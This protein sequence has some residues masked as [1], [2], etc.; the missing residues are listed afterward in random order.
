MHIRLKNKALTNYSH[1]TNYCI[2]QFIDKGNIDRWH[3]DNIHI[4]AMELVN[5]IGKILTDL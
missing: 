2:A 4:L 1:K 5:L 3:L